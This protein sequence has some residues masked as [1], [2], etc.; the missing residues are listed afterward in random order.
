LGEKTV[1]GIIEKQISR[2][3]ILRAG[4][5]KLGPLIVKEYFNPETMLAGIVA[6][7]IS[8]RQDIKNELIASAREIFSRKTSGKLLDRL[9]LRMSKGFK[10][11]KL[12]RARTRL[13]RF[14]KRKK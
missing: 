13:F 9:L 4:V 5:G 8:L 11:S 6:S 14:S 2:L 12:S 10:R 7:S 1:I 3:R